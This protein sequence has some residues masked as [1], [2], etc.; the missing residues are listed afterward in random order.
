MLTSLCAIHTE[1]QRNDGSLSDFGELYTRNK[2][3]DFVYCPPVNSVAYTC[4]RYKVTVL[5]SSKGE[6]I[7]HFSNVRFLHHFDT[8]I[9][10][11]C[12]QSVL[13]IRFSQYFD[14]F[15]AFF[16]LRCAA[17]HTVGKIQL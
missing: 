16:Q 13:N 10:V 17:L 6:A 12:S 3:R 1:T 5:F 8:Q 4:F 15:Y 14:T 11:I 9:A 7:L 2:K